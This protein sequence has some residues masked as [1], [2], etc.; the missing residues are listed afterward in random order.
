[1]SRIYERQ[2]ILVGIS[3]R[4]EILTITIDHFPVSVFLTVGV[5]FYDPSHKDFFLSK[6]I[7]GY[8]ASFSLSYCFRT[9]IL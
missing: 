4:Y 8:T 6:S 1:M 5:I 7:V 3:A 2:G 9:M